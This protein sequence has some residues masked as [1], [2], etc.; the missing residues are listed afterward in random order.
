[1]IRPSVL[2]PFKANDGKSRL[3]PALSLTGRQTLSELMLLDVLKA[4]A[5]AGLVRQCFVV[6]SDMRA[7]AI[8][9]KSGASSL[10]EPADRGVNAAVEWAMKSLEEEDRFMVV[11]SDLPLITS[12]ELRNAE[13]LGSMFGCVISPS[14]SFDGTNLLVLSRK[15]G[16]PL[17]YDSDSFW[18][19][20]RGVART[21]STL[22]VYCG[23]GIVFDVDSVGDF[24]E[25]A[26]A[27]KNA[28]SAEFARKVISTWAS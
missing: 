28:H 3:S 16:L 18:N 2:V 15:S 6:S 27:R 4:V 21:G 8:A 13:R 24:R 26:Q 9:R 7:L 25:L 11:P 17:Q 10:V 20:V 5:G 14:R 23:E 1:L 19:H 12:R 22:A